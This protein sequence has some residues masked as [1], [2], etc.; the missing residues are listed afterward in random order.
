MIRVQ[1][2]LQKAEYE[3]AKKQARRW[4]I[5]VSEFVRRAI[6]QALPCMVEKPWMKYAGSFESGDASSSQSVD[7]VVY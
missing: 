3:F 2:S 6:R 7:N 5:S 4:G 1:I